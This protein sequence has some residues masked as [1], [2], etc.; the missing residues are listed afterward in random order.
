MKISGARVQ[1]FLRQPGAET[2]AILL[3]GT[4]RGLVHERA[5]D[6]GKAAAQSLSDPF[7]VV[8][9]SGQDLKADPPRLIDEAA[10]FSMT[11]GRRVIFVM[12]ASD[13]ITPIFKEFLETAKIEALVI[14]EAGVL[15]TR[16]TLRKLFEKSSNA[17]AVGCYEDDETA[18]R[19]VILET[20][21]RHGLTA[22][23]E[24]MGFLV[25]NLGGDRLVTRAELEKLALFVGGIET[26]KDGK[27][28]AVGLED[29]MACIGDNAAMSLDLV[30]FATGSGDSGALDR[31]LGKA[32]NEGTS[33]VG[34]LRAV[35]RH[36]ERL[37]LALGLVDAGATHERALSS[38]KPAVFYKFKSEFQSQLRRWRPGPLATA[39][40]LVIEA[41]IDCKSTGFP[42]AAGC[43]RAL[44]RIAQAARA[45]KARGFTKA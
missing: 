45:G 6:L 3:F 5:R 38:L 8:E 44:M 30:V 4:D 14:V 11:G 15:G 18:L 35:A 26:G 10:Q 19:P 13:A 43:H 42:A 31:N 34:V 29:A 40:E 21:G 33:P 41:E 20:L 22:T 17:A 1:S 37:H 9:I 23:A 32:F 27:A 36:L 16:S 25:E 24:A 2:A 7:R 28:K 12:E 39:L